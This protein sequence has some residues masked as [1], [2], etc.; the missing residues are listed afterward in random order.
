MTPQPFLRAFLIAFLLFSAFDSE[1]FAKGRKSGGS[2]K[3]S[4]SYSSKSY[5]T[6]SYSKK[7]YV[8]PKGGVYHYSKSG[9]K[10]YEK[11]KK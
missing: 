5:S 6:K 1:L 10:V 4:K 11:K 9:K 3:S 8:G 2:Y 7:T